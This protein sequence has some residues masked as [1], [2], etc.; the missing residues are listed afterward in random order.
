MA[1]ADQGGEQQCRGELD[2]DRIRPHR[3]A[4]PTSRGA[5][6]PGADLRRGTTRDGEAELDQ[7]RRGQ[8]ARPRKLTARSR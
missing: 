2:A 6:R 4:T 5:D 7:Q 8:Q 3:A 1:G